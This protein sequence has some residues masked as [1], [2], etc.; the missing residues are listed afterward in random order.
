MSAAVD[1]DS[2][3]IRSG[4]QATTISELSQFVA[5]M[6]KRPLDRLLED[7]PGLASLSNSKFD[8]ARSVLRRRARDLAPVEREQLQIHAEEVA[9]GT[10]DEVAFRIRSLFH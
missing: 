3:L 8:L 6:E 7:L 4:I 1:F 9:V 2:T 10:D 5:T